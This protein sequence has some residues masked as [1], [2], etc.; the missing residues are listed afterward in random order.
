MF[1][2]GLSLGGPHYHFQEYLG[3]QLTI[4]NHSCANLGKILND[5]INPAKKGG[6]LSN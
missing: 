5:T 1:L 6:A 4:G 3:A 2:G